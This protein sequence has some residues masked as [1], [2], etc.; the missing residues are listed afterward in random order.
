MKRNLKQNFLNTV[1]GGI[2]ALMLLAAPHAL[3]FPSTGTC[4]MLTTQ[5][6][7]YGQTLP[8]T[9]GANQLSTITFTSATAGTMSTNAVDAT[10]T[11]NGFVFGGSGFFTDVPFTLTAGPI[12]GSKTLTAS[13]AAGVS[14]NANMYSVNGDKTILVQ[15]KDD[16]FTGV[17]QF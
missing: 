1:M 7:P 13:F 4:A 2:G 6:V 9:N 17:C 8:A 15:G 16:I 3:A 5:P 10:Y 14:F 11:T 12:A